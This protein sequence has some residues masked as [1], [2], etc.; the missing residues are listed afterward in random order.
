VEEDME[1]RPAIQ[2]IALEHRRRYGSRRIANPS[3]LDFGG[4]TG[5]GVPGSVIGSSMPHD[6][7]LSH[8]RLFEYFYHTGTSFPFPNTRTPMIFGRTKTLIIPSH[9]CSR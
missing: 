4:R 9:D 7:R 2:Q 5:N 1:V 3:F 8:C 6:E